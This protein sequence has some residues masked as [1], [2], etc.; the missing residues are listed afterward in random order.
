MHLSSAMKEV[1]GAIMA[2]R[3]QHCGNAAFTWMLSNVTAKRDA[4]DNVFPRKEKAGNKIDGPAVLFNAINR[5]MT[6]DSASTEF[7]ALEL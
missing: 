4:N 3:I 6:D 5:A 1:N 7:V 2:G